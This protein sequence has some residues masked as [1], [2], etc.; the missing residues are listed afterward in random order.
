M[1]NLPWV[2]VSYVDLELSS[3]VVFTDSSEDDVILQSHYSLF[4]ANISREGVVAIRL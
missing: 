3:R 4:D 1:S 2:D